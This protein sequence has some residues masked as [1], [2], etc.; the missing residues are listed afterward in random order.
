MTQG[1]S[2]QTFL[3][4]NFKLQGD[5]YVTVDYSL[6]DWPSNNG[7]RLGLRTSVGAVERISDN[8]FGG[9]MYATDVNS[10]IHTVATSDASGTLKIQRIGTVTTGSY[11][12]D[13]SWTQIGSTDF[14]NALDATIALSIWP[15]KITQGVKVAFN[16]VSVTASSIPTH[17]AIM[18]SGAD[19]ILTWPTNAAGFHLQSTTNLVSPADWSAVSL[20]PVIVNGQNTVTNAISLARTFYRLTQ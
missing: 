6:L 20:E 17:L 12:K 4:F 1:T 8:S 19:V 16:N 18:V 15:A 13:G 5:F 14:G 7:E 10:S 11:W 3:T 2:G 9:E